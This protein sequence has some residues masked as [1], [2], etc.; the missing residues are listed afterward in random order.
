MFIS[1]IWSQSSP[2]W[3]FELRKSLFLFIQAG[4]RIWLQRI[5]PRMPHRLSKWSHVNVHLFGKM[6]LIIYMIWNYKTT[7]ISHHS[8]Y[9]ILGIYYT[10]SN[11][12]KAK[13]TY[14][15]RIHFSTLCSIIAYLWNSNL[16]HWYIVLVLDS[17]LIWYQFENQNTTSLRSSSHQPLLASCV[18]ISSYNNVKKWWVN[19]YFST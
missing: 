10:I 5:P 6:L 17:L 8:L 13:T 12:S 19:I 9:S 11:H 1:N 4:M 7:C 3:N 15:H 2:C 18:D 14:F 16:W